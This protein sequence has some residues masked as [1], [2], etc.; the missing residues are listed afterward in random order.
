MKKALKII[1]PM[2]GIISLVIFPPWILVK[3]WLMPLLDTIQDQVDSA[4][5]YKLDGMIVYVDQT[6][7][8]PAFFT[9]GWKNREEQ[10]PADPQSLFKIASISKLYIA[11]ATAKMVNSQ[12]LSL[13]KTMSAFTLFLKL[14]CDSLKENKHDY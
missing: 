2:I 7:K 3:A 8:E 11:A 6:G 5:D 10:I 1:I 4:L 14:I 9:S 12:Q 13:G